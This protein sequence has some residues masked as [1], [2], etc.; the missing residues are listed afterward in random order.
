M[1]PPYRFPLAS[2]LF[3]ALPLMLGAQEKLP[4]PVVLPEPPSLITGGQSG[5]IT[6]AGVSSKANKITD[7]EAWW[8][9]NELKT[10]VVYQ[11]FPSR[12]CTS[13]S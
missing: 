1:K 7:E 11:R 5:S 8:E 6:L 3:M 13:L 10:P 2:A 4:D 12:L 9:N